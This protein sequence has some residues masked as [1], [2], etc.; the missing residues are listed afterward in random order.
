LAKAVSQD[1]RLAERRVD[2]LMDAAHAIREASAELAEI[3]A[4]LC[5]KSGEPHGFVYLIGHADAVKIGWSRN[6]PV[7]GGRLSGLQVG[8]HESLELL[9]LLVGPY[10]L[11]SQLHDRF[12]THNIR[13]EWFMRC[14]EILTYF[15]ENGIAV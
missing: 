13:G 14:E 11:E 5:D 12:S 10:S 7:T 3:E 2:E 1:M 9:G 4:S 6:H 15:E 8:T